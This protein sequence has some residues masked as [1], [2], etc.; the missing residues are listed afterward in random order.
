[1]LTKTLLFVGEG[2]STAVRIP[3][4]GGGKK[5]FAFD[6]KTGKVIW[7]TQFPSGTTGAPMT[8]LANGKQYIVVA[9][10]GLGHPAEFVALSLP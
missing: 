7:E 3:T 5:F 10:G 2:D 4:G 8:Y 1:L 6:K 9:I